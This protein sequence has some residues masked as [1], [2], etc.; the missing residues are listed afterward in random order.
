MSAYIPVLSH[1]LFTNQVQER[2]NSLSGCTGYGKMTFFLAQIEDNL[3][4]ST[5]KLNYKN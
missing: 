5:N 3:H 4:S 2:C 1:K